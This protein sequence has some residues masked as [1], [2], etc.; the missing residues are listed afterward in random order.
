LTYSAYLFDLDGT[1]LDSVALII[2]SFRHTF[3]VHGLAPHPDAVYVATMGVPLLDAMRLLLEQDTSGPPGAVAEKMVA[4]YRS[5]NLAIHDEAVRAYPGVVEAVAT[6]ANRG[7]ALA[8]VTSK[9]RDDASR[10][11]RV[12]GLAPYF[13]VVV[14]GDDVARGKPD[15]E[16][17]AL[18]LRQLVCEARSAV[19]IGD[20]PHDLEAG[21]AAGTRTAAV[22][23]GPFEQS[24]LAARAPDHWVSEP[25]ALLTL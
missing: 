5:Y 13:R 4:T 21:H 14:G 25:R 1:L 9:L 3:A 16:P 12:A 24:I 23:W 20:S 22:A 7:H 18:A 10:G 17:V 15:P 19:M 11:L 2:E 8:I 6:L